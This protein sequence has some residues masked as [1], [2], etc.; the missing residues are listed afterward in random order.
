MGLSVKLSM[1]LCVELSQTIVCGA[2]YGALCEALY[3]ALCE[4]LCGALCEALCG[5]LSDYPIRG[6]NLHPKL[7]S[8]VL[9][10]KYNREIG[11]SEL[12]PVTIAMIL[13]ETG[14]FFT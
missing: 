11:D 2:L 6:P 8:I 10:A 9:G 14:S 1:E 5:A 12:F 3:G 4:A 13:L 7:A